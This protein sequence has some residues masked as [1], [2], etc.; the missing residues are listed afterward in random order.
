MLQSVSPISEQDTRSS[1]LSPS[2]QYYED[3]IEASSATESPNLKHELRIQEQTILTHMEDVWIKTLEDFVAAGSRSAS[4]CI[5][6]LHVWRV[7]LSLLST[8]Y[9]I[10]KTPS[11]SKIR[12]LRLPT[13]KL[14]AD[15]LSE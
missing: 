7:A 1:S 10:D 12:N 11:L 2:S 15:G 9:P 5:Y 13:K 3:G 6:I 14:D 4:T 8:E